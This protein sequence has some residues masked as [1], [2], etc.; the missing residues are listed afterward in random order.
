MS[1][2]I[3][4]FVLKYPLLNLW[5]IMEHFEKKSEKTLKNCLQMF[6]NSEFFYCSFFWWHGRTISTHENV[7][8]GLNTVNMSFTAAFNV[9][10]ESFGNLNIHAT[11]TAKIFQIIY[12]WWPWFRWNSHWCA[13][14]CLCSSWHLYIVINRIYFDFSARW[15][16]STAFFNFFIDSWLFSSIILHHFA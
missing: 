5:Q 2:G 8:R 13:C 4:V 11:N 9:N 3:N 10:L 15:T 16:Q 14:A 1:F 6:E 7:V 12:T